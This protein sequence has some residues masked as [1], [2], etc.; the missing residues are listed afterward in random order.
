VGRVAVVGG[1]AAAVS[2]GVSRRQ[3]KKYAA[4][5]HDAAAAQQ[6]AYDQGQA[7]AQVAE[8]APAAT[9]PAGDDMMSQLTK[10]GEL[11]EQGVLTDAEFEA[12]KAKIL[13]S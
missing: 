1:T 5:Q 12:Q 8:P 2:G 10:L 4:E 6:D 11:R 3:S 7:D 13:A 9:A